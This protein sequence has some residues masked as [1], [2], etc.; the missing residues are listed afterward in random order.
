MEET[1]RSSLSLQRMNV[2][3]YTFDAVKT[4]FVKLFCTPKTS[5]E[6]PSLQVN[7]H[8]GSM[9]GISKNIVLETNLDNE[10]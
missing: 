2:T 4:V 6:N 7:R 1:L 3:A 8:G 9:N 5:T 10:P